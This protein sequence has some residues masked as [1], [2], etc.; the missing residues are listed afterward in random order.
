MKQKTPFH[1][2]GKILSQVM[3]PE[4]TCSV[5]A[6]W[7]P[8]FC[9]KG[10]WERFVSS[11]YKAAHPQSIMPLVGRV[12]QSLPAQNLTCKAVIRFLLLN[13]TSVST[14]MLPFNM[15]KPQIFVLT[16][17]TDYGLKISLDHQLGKQWLG[18]KSTSSHQ[19]LNNQRC[20]KGWDRCVIA[21]FFFFFGQ[22]FSV[23]LHYFFLSFLKP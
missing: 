20:N 18:S 22:L 1:D 9:L 6:L 12:I 3:I 2:Q 21:F 10:L 17:N 19:T 4:E 13:L 14:P 8:I 11:L 7:S 16:L 23:A 5:L 15:M